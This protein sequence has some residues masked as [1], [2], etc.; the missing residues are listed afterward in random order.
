MTRRLALVTLLVLLAA[1]TAFAASYVDILLYSQ[2]QDE[3]SRWQVA[4]VK[5]AIYV[6]QAHTDGSVSRSATYADQLLTS[7]RQFAANL[8]VPL[9]ISDGAA[10]NTITCGGTPRVCTSSMTDADIQYLVDLNW[11]ALCCQ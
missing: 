9:V 5:H 2:N 6:K 4:L 10:P 7:P 1:G 11:T 3:I 8:M